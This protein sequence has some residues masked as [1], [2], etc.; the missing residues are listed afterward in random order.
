MSTVH[1]AP[2]LGSAGQMHQFL[3][4]LLITGFTNE[5]PSLCITQ[6]KCYF[7]VNEHPRQQWL[8][9]GQQALCK[10][11]NG[12]GIHVSYCMIETQG[13]LVLNKTEI[14]A[15]AMLPLEQQLWVTDAQKIIYPG[16]NAD[17][18]WDLAQL[19]NQ[20]KDAINIFEFIHPDAVGVWAFD[21]SSAHEGLADDA[22]NVNCM[23]VKPGGK[24]TLLW[25]TIIPLSNPPP[26]PG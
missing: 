16:K 17:K 22:L 26:K 2:L 12:R 25:D 4:R 21:C 7:D 24:Q 5:Y 8:A 14:T 18:W 1:S 9:E 10:K 6:D 19:K 20:L 15:Q 13:H 3:S 23:N 11:G